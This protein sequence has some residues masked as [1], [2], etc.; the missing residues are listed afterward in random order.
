M[1]A[2]PYTGKL[3]AQAYTVKFAKYLQSC[4]LLLSVNETAS[5]ELFK[6]RLLKCSQLLLFFKLAFQELGVFQNSSFVRV[7]LESSIYRPLHAPRPCQPCK[8]QNEQQRFDSTCCCP[9]L[10]VGCQ[11]AAVSVAGVY[12]RAWSSGQLNAL[13]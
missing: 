5:F 11:Q 10:N 1:P 7:W 2:Q 4:L 8:R 13:L 3:A 6:H 9:H 12:R